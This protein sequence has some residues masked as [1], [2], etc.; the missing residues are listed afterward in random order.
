[1]FLTAFGA[2]VLVDVFEQV[3]EELRSERYKRLARTWLPVGAGVGAV[4][5]IGALGW[6][7]Y[8][9]WQTN[10]ADKASASYERGLEALM[11]DNAEGAQA[12]FEEAAGTASRGYKAL[13]LMQQAALAVE[14]GKT[15]DA[16]R[17]FD[18]AA[19]A[20][21]DPVLSDPAALKAAYLVMDTA[22]IAEIEKRLEPLTADKRPFRVLAREALAMAYIQNGKTAEARELFVQLQLG[23]DAPEAVRQR[24][25][26]AVQ[27]I[28]SGTSAALPKILEE[29]ARTPAQPVA[30]PAET[31]APAAAPATAPAAQ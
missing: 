25:Q 30:V 13:A 20:A 28:D 23:Q 5:L 4:A 27:A 8:Q 21:S 18:E 9:S 7:G 17:L 3:E 6:W 16:V 2:T 26:M 24:A 11:A 29:A 14:A 12:A 31:A 15:E 19:K 10:E 1:M 22:P